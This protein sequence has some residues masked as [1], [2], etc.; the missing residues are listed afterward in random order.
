MFLVVVHYSLRV[1][2]YI[3]FVVVIFCLSLHPIIQER[4]FNCATG[5]LDSIFQT[6]I[7]EKASGKILLIVTTDTDLYVK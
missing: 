4:Q 2:L 6:K 1:V 3:L 5:E 7:L